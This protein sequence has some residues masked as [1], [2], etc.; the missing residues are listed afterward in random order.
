MATC[1]LQIIKSE[2]QQSCSY[3][4]IWTTSNLQRKKIE[5]KQLHVE[6][7]ITLSLMFDKAWNVMI[8]SKEPP[9][10]VQCV[11][12]R[13]CGGRERF[14]GNCYKLC[15]IGKFL[16]LYYIY[17]A[18]RLYNLKGRSDYKIQTNGSFGKKKK[19]TCEN[20]V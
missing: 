13:F 1:I 17:A 8:L 11:V 14:K 10:F 20:L 16:I 4:I 7:M 19:R 2:Q 5:P 6:R 15:K 12:F 3:F 9:R 18:F